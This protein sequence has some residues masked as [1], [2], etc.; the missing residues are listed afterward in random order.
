MRWMRSRFSLRLALST[1]AVRIRRVVRSLSRLPPDRSR[2][3]AFFLC[4]ATI[5]FNQ[6]GT[7]ALDCRQRCLEGM[8]KAVQY[9]RSQLLTLPC[10]FR[11]AFRG[12]RTGSFDGNR[13]QRSGCV[14]RSSIE[15]M[16]A[17]YQGSDGSC[18]GTQHAARRD[19]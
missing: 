8:R 6:A 3:P 19:G 18:S 16:T 17:D 4:R 7:A 15:R 9:G 11:G 13:G 2:R 10:S 1:L 14:D 12:K 5:H